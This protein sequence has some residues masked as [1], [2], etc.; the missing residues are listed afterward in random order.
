MELQG[1]GAISK[2]K[3]LLTTSGALCELDGSGGKVERIIVPVEDGFLGRAA[4]KEA[5]FGRGGQ[6]LDLV[7]ADFRL[8][9]AIDFRTE[10]LRQKLRTETNAERGH[11]PPARTRGA[12]RVP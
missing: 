12:S 2:A 6:Q 4:A 8:R 1:V 5:I 7:P 3:R 9:I 10:G 11:V